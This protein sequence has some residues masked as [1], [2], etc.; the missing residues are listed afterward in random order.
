[1]AYGFTDLQIALAH[2]VCYGLCRCDN[3]HA[4]Q[5]LQRQF[6]AQFLR[7]PQDLRA[8]LHSQF[9]QQQQ[10]QQQQQLGH[11][12]AADHETG[13]HWTS[14]MPAARQHKQPVGLL[15]GTILTFPINSRIAVVNSELVVLMTHLAI[16]MMNSANHKLITK[17]AWAHAK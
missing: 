6:E 4:Q 16:V 8:K 13:L 5:Q 9:Q 11:R 2:D 3:A 10:Q 17:A 7:K 14:Y 12:H 1:M 15:A